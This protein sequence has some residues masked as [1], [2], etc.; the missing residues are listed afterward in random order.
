MER[1]MKSPLLTIALLTGC[2]GA[3]AATTIPAN[4]M[5]HFNAPV[6]RDAA[7]PSIDALDDYSSVTVFDVESISGSHVRHWPEPKWDSSA[8]VQ[9]AIRR[10]GYSGSTILGYN[11]KGSALTVYVKS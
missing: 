10:A 6:A 5:P 3:V 11:M 7:T 1:R 9:D 8:T 4:A 2:L